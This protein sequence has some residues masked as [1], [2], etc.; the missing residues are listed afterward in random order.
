[1][2]PCTGSFRLCFNMRRIIT[3]LFLFIAVSVQASHVA[4]LSLS[5]GYTGTAED[6]KIK[7]VFYRDC[8]GINAPAQA[9][10]MY[11]LNN[12]YQGALYLPVDTNY[13]HYDQLCLVNTTINCAGG[14]GVE[15]W[16]YETVIS[17]PQQ[18]LYKFFCGTDPITIQGSNYVEALI[19]I[20]PGLNNHL[21]EFTSHPEFTFCV[22]YPVSYPSFATEPD[23]DSLVYSFV[24]AMIYDTSSQMLTPFVYGVGNSPSNFNLYMSPASFSASGTVNF[25]PSVPAVG[26]IVIQADEYRNGTW[27]GSTQRMMRVNVINQG[28]VN[29][30]SEDS[31]V[32]TILCTPNPASDKLYIKSQLAVEQF[33]ITDLTGRIVISAT[34]VNDEINISGLSQGIYA[35]QLVSSGKTKT[36]HFVKQD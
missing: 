35:L 14:F 29:S 6:Y 20:Q 9:Y 7:Y 32:N 34:N 13:I 30:I 28:I 17:L 27:A 1:M 11:S 3:F 15:V 2:Q 24:P 19:D 36:I 10:I 21:P 5:V 4:G 31:E 22:T 18:G 25:T 23:G 33:H 8:F 12:V 26:V 16:V